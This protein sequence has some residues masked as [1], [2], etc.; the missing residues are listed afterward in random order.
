MKMAATR[1]VAYESSPMPHRVVRRR[2]RQLLARFIEPE[3]K[4]ATGKYWID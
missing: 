4:Y 1:K 3:P 2:V